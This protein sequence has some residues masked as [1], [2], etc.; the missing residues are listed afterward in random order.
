MAERTFEHYL[1]WSWL[2]LDEAIDL[3]RRLIGIHRASGDWSTAFNYNKII[4]SMSIAANII[5]TR[6]AEA[7]RAQLELI[8]D[9]PSA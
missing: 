8:G 2:D 3:Y 6:A 5:Q 7:K 1:R 9:E 4:T